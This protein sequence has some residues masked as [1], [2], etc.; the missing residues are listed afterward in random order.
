MPD[1]KI[2]QG[3]RH[4]TAAMTEHYTSFHLEDY[5]EVVAALEDF[6]EGLES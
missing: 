1:A 6:T 4:K 5:Q 3:T 2:R